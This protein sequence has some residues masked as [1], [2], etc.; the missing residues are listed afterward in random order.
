MSTRQVDEKSVLTWDQMHRWKAGGQPH[1]TM[2]LAIGIDTD[3]AG[4][5]AA[6]GTTSF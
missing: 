5:R 1:S 4:S 6:E 3:F 2:T